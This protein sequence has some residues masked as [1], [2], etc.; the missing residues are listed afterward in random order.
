MR[1]V[2]WKREGMGSLRQAEAEPAMASETLKS[3]SET[4]ETETSVLCSET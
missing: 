1:R 4:D 3:L 2:K